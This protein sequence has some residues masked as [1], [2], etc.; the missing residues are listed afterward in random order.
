MTIF[1]LSQFFFHWQHSCV[2][3]FGILRYCP[4]QKIMN[5]YLKDYLAKTEK[6][7][8]LCPALN[9]DQFVLQC[10]ICPICFNHTKLYD[11]LINEIYRISL[12]KVRGH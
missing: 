8:L 3:D 6:K 7:M 10:M 9:Q 11:V 12:N 1:S 4:G 5:M 2:Y